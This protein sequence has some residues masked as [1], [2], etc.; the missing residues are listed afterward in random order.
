M[1]TNLLGVNRPS[2]LL[3]VLAAALGACDTDKPIAPTIKEAPKAAAPSLD[4]SKTGAVV[5]RIV[6]AANNV[7]P[8][9]GGGF[10]V[11]GPGQTTWS[12]M[13]AGPNDQQYDADPAGGVIWIKNLAPGQYKF[14]EALPPAGYGVVNPRCQTTGVYVGSTSGLW[15][16]NLPVAHIKWVVTDYASNLIG[17]ASFTLDSNNVKV[18]TVGDG[19]FWDTDPAPGKFDVKIPYESYW[20][21]C[22]TTPPAGYLFPI[23]AVTCVANNIKQG[24]VQDFGNFG[25]NPVYSVYWKV[26]DAAYTLI[27]PSTFQLKSADGL[28]NFSA[29][30]NSIN[31]FDPVLGKIAVKLPGA[32]GKFWSICETV[33]PANHWNAQPA[34]KRISVASNQPASADYFINPE[35]QVYYPGPNPIR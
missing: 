7:I 22:V 26:A 12:I 6:D 10:T 16:K 4:P 32:G 1:R 14:C 18:V 3:V 21:L 5:I 33:P 19:S 34:C 11:E 28:Y 23:N 27:G 17:G 31:D 25:V 2:T 9:T 29:V 15:F 8:I 13:D 35:K 30:D 24:T 20:K